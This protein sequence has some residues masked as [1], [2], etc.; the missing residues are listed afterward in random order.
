[1]ERVPA[2]LNMAHPAC[3]AIL[4]WSGGTDFQEETHSPPRKATVLPHPR[5]VV[6]CPTS[7]NPHRNLTDQSVALNAICGGTVYRLP[8]TSA[9]A[10]SR[11]VARTK[12]QS[13]RKH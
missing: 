2:P 11:L 6:K 5:S 9:S 12:A 3:P 13:S 7:R 1:M 4:E 8:Y 10:N